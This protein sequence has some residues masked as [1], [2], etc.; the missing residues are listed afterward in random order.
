MLQVD[1][2]HVGGVRFEADARGHRVI[3]DQP[4]SNGGTD[5]GMTPPEFLLAALGTCAAYYSVE[6]LKMKGLSS[7][8]LTVRV[9]AEKAAQPVRLAAFHI[10]VTIPGLAEAHREGVSKA[11]KKCLIHNT[12]LKT[13]LIGVSVNSAQ[14]PVLAAA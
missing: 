14:A 5:T 11:V 4:L 7:S 1:V 10:E 2:R 13:P 3:C 6:Y 9:E 12:L 8:G